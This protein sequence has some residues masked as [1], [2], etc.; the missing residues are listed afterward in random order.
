MDCLSNGNGTGKCTATS[1]NFTTRVPPGYSYLATY[2][3]DANYRPIALPATSC[4]LVGVGKLNSNIATHIFQVSGSRGVDTCLNPPTA[5]VCEV[6]DNF[7]DINNSTPG[8]TV[9][10]RDQAVVTQDGS[11]GPTPTG[12][13]TFTRYTNAD[14]TGTATVD[15]CGGT[16][17]ALDGTGAALST[18]VNLGATGL[19]FKA[20]Y[21]GDSV[22]NGSETSRCEPVCAINSAIP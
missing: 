18:T 10:T 9:T 20:V 7:I 5:G 4:E 17:C 2:N 16:G 14:C 8:S 22:Y 15:S 11:G 6:T 12:S 13:V 1:S 3:G 21:G 19:S